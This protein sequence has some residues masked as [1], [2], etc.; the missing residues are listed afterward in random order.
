MEYYQHHGGDV[1]NVI[2]VPGI[3][4][5]KTKQANNVHELY[6]GK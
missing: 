1:Q 2:S 4:G 3:P 5:F 6:S